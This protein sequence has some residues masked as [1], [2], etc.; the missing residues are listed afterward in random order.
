MFAQTHYPD[1]NVRQ[2][3]SD[4]LELAEAKIQVAETKLF[5]KFSEGLRTYF[6]KSL[7]RIRC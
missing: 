2:F 6:S 3:M 7:L 1:A 5:T 4:K